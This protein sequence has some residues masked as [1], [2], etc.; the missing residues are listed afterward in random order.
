[1]F[2]IDFSFI[3]KLHRPQYISITFLKCAN[4]RCHPGT[5][6]G[7]EKGEGAGVRVPITRIR[8]ASHPLN[9]PLNSLEKDP[10]LLANEHDE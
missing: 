10:F 8:L 1:M 4:N 5:D 9:P 2:H 6:P 7:F 3:A